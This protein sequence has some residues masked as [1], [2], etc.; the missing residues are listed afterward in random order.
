[1]TST[2]GREA[3]SDFPAVPPSHDF[4]RLPSNADLTTIGKGAEKLHPD[5]KFYIECLKYDLLRCQLL[6]FGGSFYACLSLRGFVFTD[7]GHPEYLQQLR[8]FIAAWRHV[9][10]FLGN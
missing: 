4:I 10:E 1:M 3:A 8:Y 6:L 2:L 9:K 7:A 5:I